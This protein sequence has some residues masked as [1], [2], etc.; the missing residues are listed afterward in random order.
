MTPD[1]LLRATTEHS[2][3][4]A[5]FVRISPGTLK[6]IALVIS[7]QC[8][9]I[10]NGASDCK[11]SA[12]ADIK[13][14]GTAVPW[15]LVQ[16]ISKRSALFFYSVLVRFAAYSNSKAAKTHDTWM[17]VMFLC[18][19]G[20]NWP[21]LIS[22]QIPILCTFSYSNELVGR[23]IPT[24]SS[25]RLGS[26]MSGCSLQSGA[27]LFTGWGA[28]FCLA[29]HLNQSQKCT[30]PFSKPYRAHPEHVWISTTERRSHSH[31]MQIGC[32]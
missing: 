20:A 6:C 7:C 13:S 18:D 28:N 27:F 2:V 15:D 19:P 5:P 21:E 11:R 30:G 1:N 17:R 8:Q 16:C 32:R 29:S 24:H 31:V 10:V 9:C 14:Q 12:C 22:R 26:H 3:G 4:M 23:V 25:L